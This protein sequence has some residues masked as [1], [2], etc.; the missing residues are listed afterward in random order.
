M[1][2]FD[3]N[4]STNSRNDPIEKCDCQKIMTCL[5]MSFSTEFR[6]ENCSI[7]QNQCAYSLSHRQNFELFQK[8]D[9]II[10][11]DE[12]N[13]KI[14]KNDSLKAIIIMCNSSKCDNYGCL[15]SINYMR[16]KIMVE[17]V[18]FLKIQ[19]TTSLH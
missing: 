13:I 6:G 3:Q 14:Y 7:F 15:I 4:K 9:D 18:Q 12:N 8:N 19:M 17:F 5:L 10:F 1:K 11:H 2:L 16:V